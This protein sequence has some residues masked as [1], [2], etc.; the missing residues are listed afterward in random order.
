[1]LEK[2]KLKSE[3]IRKE[4]I[5]STFNCWLKLLLKIFNKNQGNLEKFYNNLAK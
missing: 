4:K 1:M 5:I 3:N 2:K